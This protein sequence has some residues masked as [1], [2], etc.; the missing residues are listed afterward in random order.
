L[1]FNL[2]FI[3]AKSTR[4]FNIFTRSHLRFLFGGLI[5][6][7]V[8][9]L[10]ASPLADSLALVYAAATLDTL[11]LTPYVARSFKLFTKAAEKN[12]SRFNWQDAPA[13][14]KGVPFILGSTPNTSAWS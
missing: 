14:H 11:P 1:P 3:T 12:C 4:R 9:K 8:G 13:D 7:A 10:W 5:I 2:L 6:T